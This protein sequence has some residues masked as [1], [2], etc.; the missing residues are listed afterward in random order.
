MA[1]W[2][3][4]VAPFLTAGGLRP[5]RLVH[6]AFGYGLFTGGFGLHYGVEA[7]GA[8]VVPAAAGN[9]ERQIMLLRDL[10]A[11]AIVC[12]PS[13]ALTIAEVMRTQGVD[14]AS[15]PLACGH[16]G[17]EPWTEDMR[18]AIEREFGIL[19]FNNYGCI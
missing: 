17:G 6:I 1:L 2:A 19:A 8:G 14:P 10:G 16:F 3:G 11:H 9:T 15:L 18:H 12:T 5:G 4:L 13:Y 7:A